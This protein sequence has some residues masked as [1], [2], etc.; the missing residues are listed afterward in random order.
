MLSPGKVTQIKGMVI[1]KR[2][3]WHK[4]QN[5]KITKK[6]RRL[7]L[8]KKNFQQETVKTVKEGQTYQTN[9][10]A[11]TSP[12]IETI[13]SIATL[14]NGTTF[15]VFDIEATGFSRSSDI[16]QL[17]A[18]DG[19]DTFNVY[20]DP[21]MPISQK[22]TEITG[23]SYCFQKNQ[24][25]HYGKEIDSVHIHQAL[26]S[27]LDFLKSKS[28]PVLIGHNIGSYGVPILSRLLEEFGLLA[29]FLQLISGC[30]DTLKLSRK[31]FSKSETPNY[32]QSTLVKA[33]LGKDYDAHNALEDV[34]ILFQ[35]FKEKLHSHC[36]NMDIFPF[37]LVKLEASYAS[38]VLKKKIS[39]AVAR[40]LANSGLGLNHSHLSF[41]RDQ[42]ADVKSILQERGFKGKTIRC[43]QSFFEDTHSE[44]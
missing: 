24:M 11:T 4:R 20:I 44:E 19:K 34:K 3:L 35:L 18:Y 8:K 10:S 41:K 16:T 36:R 30:I 39:K 9:T 38:V 43:I 32:K 2:K 14:S 7:L 17:F 6:C 25:Y 33:I 12:D 15:V 37:N 21:R 29:A 42:N 27:F 31:V 1:D 26:L 5:S 13:P 22:A 23:L 28:C 40:R